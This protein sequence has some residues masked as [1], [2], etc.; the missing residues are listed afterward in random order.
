MNKIN[1][2]EIAYRGF[3]TLDRLGRVFIYKEKFY[4][5]IYPDK[6]EYVEELLQSG[7]LA[8][9]V[10]SG[11]FIETTKTAFYCDSFPLILEHKRI[12]SSLPTDWSFSM[13]KD[14]VKTILRVNNICNKY[15]YKLG[16]AHPYNIC[17]DRVQ[18]KWIDFGSIQKDSSGIW[19]ARQEFTDC[20]IVPLAFIARNELLQGYSLLLAL[21]AFKLYSKP[22]RDTLSYKSFIEMIATGTEPFN[23]DTADGKWIDSFCATYDN[24]TSYWGN[25]QE[26]AASIEKNLHEHAENRFQRFFKIPHLVK[27]YASDA[28]TALDL[29]GN[30]GQASFIFS[31]TCKFNKIINV[32]YDS[33]AIEESYRFLKNHPSINAET[34]LL[35]F[36][37]PVQQDSIENFRSD[38]VFALAVTHHL[39]LTQGYKIDGIFEQIKL[40]S[41]KYVFI[42]FMPLGLWGGD[43]TNKPEIPDWY[44]LE[45][46]KINFQK[47][48]TLLG[49]EVLEEHTINDRK[50]AH[51]VLF[52]GKI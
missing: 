50:E 52:I 15:G 14:A 10:K 13:L 46:F 30:S 22:F 5:G 21:R 6:V 23:E 16:D 33:L 18:P 1:E 28:K 49:V 12:T 35:N 17:F 11:A 38:L 24:D 39:L 3:T 41:N 2:T 40:Y 9:L 44:T 4:R 43:P 25:Y 8:E 36:M 48:F 29:A 26:N 42:E 32:D 37:L 51:R 19:E 7:L 47:H 34:Y 20:S 45:W 31:Q 27:K